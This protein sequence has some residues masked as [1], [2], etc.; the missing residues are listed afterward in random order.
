MNITLLYA[1]T[2]ITSIAAIAWCLIGFLMRVSPKA[3]RHFCIANVL[4]AVAVCLIYFRASTPSYVHYQGGSL[5]LLVSFS[6]YYSGICY[7]LRPASFSVR[8]ICAPMVLSLLLLAL[9]P[10]ASGLHAAGI[11]VSVCA[12]W[13]N[14]NSFQACYKGLEALQP[15][16]F[17]RTLICSPFLAAVL[18]ML[19]RTFKLSYMYL[20]PAAFDVNPAQGYAVEPWYWWVVFAYLLSLNTIIQTLTAT[21]LVIRMRH[22]AERDFLTGSLNR[23]CIVNNFQVQIERSLRFQGDLS[24]ILFDLDYF[25]KINDLHG[26]NVGDEA[27]KHAVGIAQQAIRQI[28]SLGRYGGEEFLVLLPDTTASGAVETAQRIRQALVATPLQLA[29][30]IVVEVRASFGVAQW[31][32]NENHE[33]LVKRADAAMYLA[34]KLGRNQVQLDTAVDTFPDSTLEELAAQPPRADVVHGVHMSV[35]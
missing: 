18:G 28:D 9:P 7:L 19:W 25:K 35:A 33:A 27:L 23:R 20:N 34:K 21:R 26:H 29:N 16:R 11:V 2:L 5:A 3:S 32:T 8:K 4:A 24:C 13:I 15:S 22:L 6:F 31:R 12:A 1:I 30:G 10:D 17:N 14:A